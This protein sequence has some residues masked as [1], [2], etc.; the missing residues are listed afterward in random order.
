MSDVIAN[1]ADISS[2]R[3]TIEIAGLTESWEAAATENVLAS[4]LA[5]VEIVAA[6][7]RA[8]FERAQELERRFG[9]IID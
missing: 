4:A 7:L 6:E 5:A 8:R 1:A 2:V 3:V 9:E